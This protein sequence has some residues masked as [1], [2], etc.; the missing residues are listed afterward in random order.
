M[1]YAFRVRFQRSPRATLNVPD[2]RGVRNNLRFSA[3]AQVRTMVPASPIDDSLLTEL[4]RSG[5]LK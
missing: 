4:V 5:C 2:S 1:K 3:N